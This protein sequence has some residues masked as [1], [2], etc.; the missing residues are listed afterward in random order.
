MVVLLV[1]VG[2]VSF[3][4]PPDLLFGDSS[5]DVDRGCSS[6]VTSIVVPEAALEIARLSWKSV[7]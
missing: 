7:S 3:V 6:V 5:V 2:V 1:E 4:D